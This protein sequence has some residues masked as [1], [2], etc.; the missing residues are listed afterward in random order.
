MFQSLACEKRPFGNS[1]INV[2]EIGLGT[3]QWEAV[4]ASPSTRPMRA[5]APARRCRWHRFHRHRRRLF[6]RGQRKGGGAFCSLLWPA[7][8]RGQQV[9]PAI[10]TTCGRGVHATSPC[11]HSSKPASRVLRL[12]CLDLIQLHC[13]PM[14]VYYRPEVFEVSIACARRARSSTS[15]ERGEGRGG[16]QG[17]RIRQCAQR[18]DHLQHVRLRPPSGS[19]LRPRGA[20]GRH[21]ARALASGL[22]T[23]QYKSFDG[24]RPRRSPAVQS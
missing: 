5:R 9:W 15:G 24:V 3:W 11:A 21:C 18:A 8:V 6:G 14:T 1:G 10:V 22:L 23:G 20:G 7:P 12:E 13:P 2:S 17:H 16:P 4:G 19:S